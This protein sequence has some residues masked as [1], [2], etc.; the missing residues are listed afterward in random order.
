M[1]LKHYHKSI[2]GL[3]IRL[4]QFS[5]N[6]KLLL[7]K[8]D[9]NTIDDLEDIQIDHNHINLKSSLNTPILSESEI[10][11]IRKLLRTKKYNACISNAI[12]L[13]NN[14]NQIII[15]C[16]FIKTIHA[17]KTDLQKEGINVAIIY[18]ATPDEEREIILNEYKKGLYDVLITNPH[19]LG[20][21]VSLHHNAHHALYL[22]YSFN[23]THMLQSRDRIHRLG[24]NQ[25]QET[26]YLYYV[27]E[28]Q[29]IY[30]STIDLKI[31][32]RLNKKKDTMMQAI[33]EDHLP[34]FTINYDELGEI[35]EMMKEAN[36]VYE[37]KFT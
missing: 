9:K 21:S 14:G 31:Y 26:N 33:E 15:W 23:L 29:D 10:N 30:E 12:K 24:L 3:Y 25:N 28:G 1:H 17:V 22:E 16:I 27:L 35:E 11:L 4:M 2:F 20:E 13:I 36:R 37:S 5:S 32:N 34:D 19:T 8:I 6:P 7:D 18:G